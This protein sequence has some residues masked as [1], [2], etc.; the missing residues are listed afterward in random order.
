M[1]WKDWPYWLRGGIIGIIVMISYAVLGWV[2]TRIMLLT[3]GDIPK[4]LP[5]IMYMIGSTPDF[6]AMI[7]CKGYCIGEEGMA[8]IITAPI[9]WFIDG[10]II[11]F[12]VG[13]IKSKNNPSFH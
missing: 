12:I 4:G 7:V 11:G 1:A 8:G 2:V 5:D 6:L 3:I 13:K 9:S 10:A